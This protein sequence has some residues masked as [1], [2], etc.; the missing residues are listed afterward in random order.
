M[1][2]R[3][4]GV[5]VHGNLLWGDVML[6][7]RVWGGKVRSWGSSAIGWLVR[8]WGG[9]VWSFEFLSNLDGK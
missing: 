8:V 2:E 4:D 9:K 5:V 6:G 3:M 1:M 7:V